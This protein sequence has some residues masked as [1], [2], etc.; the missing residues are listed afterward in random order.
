ML[1]EKSMTNR[2]RQLPK[3]LDT[4]YVFKISLKYSSSDN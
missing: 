3:L 1:P 4:D 2:T